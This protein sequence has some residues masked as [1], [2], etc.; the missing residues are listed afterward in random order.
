MVTVSRSY[1]TKIQVPVACPAT[2]PAT[3][4]SSWTQPQD[5]AAGSSH[6]C[7]LLGQVVRICHWIQR[8]VQQLDPV[9]GPA[10]GFSDWGTY[11]AIR[12]PGFCQVQT[13]ILPEVHFQYSMRCPCVMKSPLKLLV[14]SFYPHSEPFSYSVVE[15]FVLRLRRRSF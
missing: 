13:P 15:I 12:S 6:K 4:S 1:N 3:G 7:E 14:R 10:A 5:P 9:A 2:G 11:L 8:L